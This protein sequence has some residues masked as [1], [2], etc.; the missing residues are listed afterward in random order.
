MLK[1]LKILAP[2]L[3]GT[4]GMLTM[5]YVLADQLVVDMPAPVRETFAIDA[6][7]AQVGTE[8]VQESAHGL[9]ASEPAESAGFGLGR[10][11]LEVEVAAWDIDIRPDGQGL[12]AGSGDVWTGEE[13]YV[14]NCA[15]CHGDFGE[16]VGRWPV[17]AGGW[18]T[19]ERQD[20]VKTIGSYWPYLST[21]Y[22]YINRA[23]PF[24]NAQSLEPDEI[25]AITAY[26]LYLNNIVEDD[27]E[28]SN[29]TFLDVEMPNADGFFPDDRAD[30]ELVA[31]SGEVCMERCK[32]SVEIT[33]RAAV[34]DVTPDS[35]DGAATEAVSE[36]SAEVEYSD[37]E[38]TDAQMADATEDASDDMPEQV[39]ES[40]VPDSAEE[41]ILAAADPALIAA[42][43]GVF[44]ACKACHAVGEGAAN[45]S[46][47]QLNA[48]VGRPIGSVEGFRYSR[49]FD[50]AHDAGDVWTMEALTAF[51][52]NPREAMPG[53]KM[54]Y[55]GIQ[56]PADI[57]AVIIYLEQASAE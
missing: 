23:M 38:V 47:P 55:R 35:E 53:T 30:T 48:I 4:A 14:E 44:R 36:A 2:A 29:E 41:V 12:P 49:S 3:G 17:L 42:G 27:F 18:D 32:D 56:D 16:A 52:A 15:M 34:L 45:K 22:D 40:A 51:L 10:P 6:A 11:A 37:G 9:V 46:G 26:L 13:V 24:G 54:S 20:P 31:F 21:V 39:A 8:T 43:E 1:Y 57:D 25:Y 33:M 50:E 7:H 28:L 19:L 5:A